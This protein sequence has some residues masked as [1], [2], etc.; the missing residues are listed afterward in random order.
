MKDFSSAWTRSLKVTTTLIVSLTAGILAGCETTPTLPEWQG[1]TIEEQ[2]VR[3]VNV[4]QWPVIPVETVNGVRV[5]ILNAEA[6]KALEICEVSLEETI[7]LAES[8]AEGV[9]A[10]VE[11][12]NQI[13]RI[14]QLQTE[15]AERE[16]Q[17]LERD[18]QNAELEGWIY[19]LTTLILAA[20]AL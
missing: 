2:G 13:N 18:R 8:N 19:K 15:L 9:D 12:V 7:R 1:V 10:L 17:R 14:G 5:G 3:P 16:L 4:C 11:R 20:A 6:G